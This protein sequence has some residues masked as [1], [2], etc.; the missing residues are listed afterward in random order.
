MSVPAGL[1]GNAREFELAGVVLH[2]CSPE[3]AAHVVL[4]AVA[5]GRPL[6][7]HLCNAYTVGLADK[8]AGYAAVLR[9]TSLNL[10]DGTPLAWYA[11]LVTRRKAL[12]PV[13]GPTFMRDVLDKRGLRHFLYGGTAVV[14]EELRR[15]VEREHPQADV[16]G[17]IAP[18]FGPVN[19]ADLADAVDSMKAAGAQ[20]VWVGLGTPK[21]DIVL[22]TIAESAHVVAIGVGAAFDFLSGTTKEAPAFLHRTGFEWLFRLAVEPRRLWRRYL[23]GNVDFVRVAGRGLREARRGV[24]TPRA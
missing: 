2:D 23:V 8:D 24:T 13:R 6:A 18:P 19:D 7:V 17:C 1:S 9:R 10:I 21:Q 12:G 4:E 14:L 3:D 11:G 20:V 16:V 5:A 15:Y 22:P